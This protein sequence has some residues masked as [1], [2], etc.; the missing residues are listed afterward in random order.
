MEI[1]RFSS[2]TAKACKVWFSTRAKGGGVVINLKDWEQY[3]EEYLKE[4]EKHAGQIGDQ[5]GTGTG[6]A[7]GSILGYGLDSLV[8]VFS[9]KNTINGDDTYF[10]A[11]KEAVYGSSNL[12]VYAK[13]DPACKKDH[14]L[15]KI[16]M[17]HLEKDNG[18][19]SDDA[20]ADPDY[21]VPDL[22]N[23]SS[24]IFFR[25][26]NAAKGSYLYA[27]D[28][29]KTVSV[30]RRP[31]Y[32]SDILPVPF[33]PK[34][35]RDYWTLH[36]QDAGDNIHRVKILNTST[37][38]WLTCFSTANNKVG[39]YSVDE[40]DYE[41]QHWDLDD[42]GSNGSY[43]QLKNTK[44]GQ[45]LVGTEEDRVFMYNPI[46][47]GN[48]D[49]T[50]IVETLT[51]NISNVPKSTDIYLMHAATGLII[52]GDNNDNIILR[53]EWSE[54]AAYNF[55]LERISG[56]IYKLRSTSYNGSSS[57]L[58][59]YQDGDYL[60]LY[61]GNATDYPD[62]H[63]EIVMQKNHAGFYLRNQAPK[64]G[65]SNYLY[66]KDGGF[67]LYNGPYDNDQLWVALFK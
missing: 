39:L 46:R 41:D 7:A 13:L 9:V 65:S 14:E 54:G 2:R 25:A 5:S 27:Q 42:L 48:G 63:W 56:D 59:Y 30:R 24:Q 3:K 28:D 61:P 66:Y 52:G 6:T 60:G 40:P 34:E 31:K 33:N 16:W 10:G 11:K 49:Q 12:V 57:V 47:D 21:T 38:K 35:M 4:Y 62:Q 67:G 32:L 18:Q 64:R 15:G 44:V 1:P 45:N 58:T 20:N 43:V 53:S 37:N 26:F 55:T 22:S 29:N 8:E 17:L 36:P 51:A 19:E 23:Y 50:W